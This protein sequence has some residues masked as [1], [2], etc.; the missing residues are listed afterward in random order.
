MLPIIASTICNPPSQPF[1]RQSLFSVINADR[2]WKFLRYCGG[3]GTL[4]RTG[5][6]VNPFFGVYQ[7]TYEIGMLR[8]MIQ[9]RLTWVCPVRKYTEVC[10][11][12]LRLRGRTAN[13]ARRCPN[14]ICNP[15]SRSFLPARTSS[16]RPV[17]HSSRWQIRICQKLMVS[18]D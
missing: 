6:G 12:V 18:P 16:F 8:G 7:Q 10:A 15:C 14:T 1:C 17:K 13:A 3:A 5:P 2:A 9:K 4:S 11:L